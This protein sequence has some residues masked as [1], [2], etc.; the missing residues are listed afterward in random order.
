MI[1][2]KYSSTCELLVKKFNSVEF[3]T[4]FQYELPDKYLSAETKFTILY[5][6]YFNSL[7]CYGI[8]LIKVGNSFPALGIFLNY[9]TSYTKMPLSMRSWCPLPMHLV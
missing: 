8:A 1:H 9:H 2:V 3:L 6:E 5:Y 4:L 7:I